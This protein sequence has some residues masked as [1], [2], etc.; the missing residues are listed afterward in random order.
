M[1]WDGQGV[2]ALRQHLGVTQQ[3]LSE[4]LGVRQQTVSEW[5]SGKYQ[6]RGASARVLTMV[7]ERAG[8]SYQ[9]G[10]PTE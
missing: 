1:N 2:R 3:E 8:F 5:E 4:E 7:A 9:A 6:P 10:S